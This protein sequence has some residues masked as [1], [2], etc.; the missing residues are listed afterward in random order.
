MNAMFSEEW[1]GMSWT[2]N[3]YISVLLVWET[4]AGRSF[5]W[6]ASC[7]KQIDYR[8]DIA[9]NDL[10]KLFGMVCALSEFQQALPGQFVT[11]RPLRQVLDRRPYI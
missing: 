11:E 8:N 4:G 10:H 3:G 6:S 7:L 5:K 9:F 2:T 1:G